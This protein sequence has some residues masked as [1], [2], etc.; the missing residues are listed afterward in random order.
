MSNDNSFHLA[1]FMMER[2]IKLNL[3]LNSYRVSQDAEEMMR[4]GKRL[5]NYSLN[6]CNAG[7][8]DRQEASRDKIAEKA[9]ELAKTYNLTAHCYGDP[10]GYVLRLDGEGVE[11]NGW[12]DGFG[13][14]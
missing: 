7:L 14:A 2:A 8:N 4:L 9:K 12:G 13:V 11:R 5:A 1:A 10:R 3:G 6:D